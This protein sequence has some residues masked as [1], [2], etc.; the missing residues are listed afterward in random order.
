MAKFIIQGG[1]PLR[2]SVRIGGAKNAS[3]KLMIAS[4]LVSGETR[5]LNLSQ[6]GDV[7][8]TAEI[9]KTLNFQ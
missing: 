4:L 6:I 2:G 3:F 9:L 7:G 8:I 1:N 5:L